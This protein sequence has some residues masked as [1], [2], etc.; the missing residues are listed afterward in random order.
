MGLISLL[1]P[2]KCLEHLLNQNDAYNFSIT[3]VSVVKMVV[4]TSLLGF[5]PKCNYSF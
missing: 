3:A 4:K 5:N 2:C 1:I